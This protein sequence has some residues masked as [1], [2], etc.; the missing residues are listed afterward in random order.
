[1]KLVVITGSPHKRGTSALLAEEFIKG[2]K[3]EKTYLSAILN[4]KG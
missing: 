1:M 3:G 4:L 2:A